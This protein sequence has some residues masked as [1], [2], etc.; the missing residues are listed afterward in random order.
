MTSQSRTLEDI[1]TDRLRIIQTIAQANTDQMRLNQEAHGMM[2]LDMKDDRDGV[3]SSEHGAAQA[4]NETA[5][6]ENLETING[7]EQQLSSLDEELAQ[8]AQEDTK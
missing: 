5:M 3:A 4:R 1:L 7:L 8:A 6:Q 2:V